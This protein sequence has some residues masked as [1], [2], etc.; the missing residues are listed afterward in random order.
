MDAKR[1]IIFPHAPVWTDAERAPA[2]RILIRLGGDVQRIF[3]PGSKN[4]SQFTAYLQRLQIPVHRD[5]VPLIVLTE[6]F[7][8]PSMVPNCRSKL[9]E[10]IPALGSGIWLI[11]YDGRRDIAFRAAAEKMG[12]FDLPSMDEF[13]I[14]ELPGSEQAP[15]QRFLIATPMSVDV[16]LLEAPRVRQLFPPP[17]R[18][19]GLMP[20]LK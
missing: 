7:P 6:T 1:F 10:A 4:A 16:S 19:S 14:L 2:Y 12:S 9:V 18:P 13:P 8:F 15:A 11:W 3:E 17:R 5:E 20:K